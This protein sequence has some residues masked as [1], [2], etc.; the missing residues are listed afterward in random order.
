LRLK[1]A[2]NVMDIS[3]KLPIEYNLINTFRGI[4]FSV[5]QL[6]N[7][8]INPFFKILLKDITQ[9]ETTRGPRGHVRPAG[10]V[11]PTKAHFKFMNLALN[12]ARGTQI[13]AQC[14]PWMKIVSH[15]WPNTSLSKSEIIKLQL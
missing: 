12:S 4:P 7:S 8:Q 9:E 2:L 1:R 13:K 14:G 6:V 3:S 11:H 5:L 10:H 15:A